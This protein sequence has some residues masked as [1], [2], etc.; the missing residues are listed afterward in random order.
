MCPGVTGRCGFSTVVTVTPKSQLV[1]KKRRL[2]SE[3]MNTSHA[4]YVT[5]CKVLRTYFIRQIHLI[6]IHL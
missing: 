4:T 5:Q 1:C 3:L 6:N 2:T